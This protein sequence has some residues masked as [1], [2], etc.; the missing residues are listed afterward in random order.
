[1]CLWSP[2]HYYLNSLQ[3]YIRA[4]KLL[5]KRNTL[6]FNKESVFSPEYLSSL[7]W[8]WF[9]S[10]F[11][12]ELKWSW[13]VSAFPQWSNAFLSVYCPTCLSTRAVCMVKIRLPSSAQ[14]P[15]WSNW[16][17]SRRSSPGCH[18]SW[19]AIQLNSWIWSMWRT[20]YSRTLS[21]LLRTTRA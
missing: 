5:N 12:N 15:L 7:L 20:R 3:P 18:L 4:C 14:H 6:E 21:S 16:A 8:F 19:T 11:F 1:M 2:R 17:C 13:K 10:V 9:C